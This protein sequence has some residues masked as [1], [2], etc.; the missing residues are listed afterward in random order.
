MRKVVILLL[1]LSIFLA[2]CADDISDSE[3]EEDETYTVNK[4]S[5][6]PKANNKLHDVKFWAYQIQDQTADGA[7]DALVDS[8]YDMLVIDDVST[9]VEDEDYDMKAA[10]EKLK[11]SGKIVIAYID[12]G[13]AEDYRWYWEK[14]WKVGN[15]EFIETIDPDGWSGNY[16]VQ[17]WEKEWQD[18]IYGDEDAYIDKLIANGF[19]GIYLDWIEAYSE[20]KVMAAAKKEGKDREKEMINFIKGF[21]DYSRKKKPGFLV[22]AQNAVELGQY[23]EYLKIIDGVAQEQIWFDGSADAK[24]SASEG[25]YAMPSTGLFSSEYY[26][27]YLENFKTANVPVFTVDYATKKENVDKAYKVSLKNGFNPY[28]SIRSLSRLTKTPPPGY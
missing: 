11:K 27:D 10:V 8:H 26:L 18:I 12:I 23:E 9:V 21:S 20:D 28:V 16:P 5:M 4:I 15:P 24:G 14:G 2:G 3:D 22:I 1:V 19:D 25:D 13:E 6:A 17:Y 7:L